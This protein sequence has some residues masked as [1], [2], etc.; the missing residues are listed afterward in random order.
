MEKTNWP[1]EAVYQRV[2][3]AAVFTLLNSATSMPCFYV[4]HPLNLQGWEEFVAFTLFPLNLERASTLAI[5]GK[6]TA[7][8]GEV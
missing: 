2:A 5:G 7:D 4:T 3:G 8:P 1:I 6:F